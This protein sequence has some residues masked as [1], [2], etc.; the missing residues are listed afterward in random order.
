MLNN[1]N[2][3]PGWHPGSG[4]KNDCAT[5]CSP[6]SAAPATSAPVI[7]LS[8]ARRIGGPAWRRLR[9]LQTLKDLEAA[10]LATH[11]FRDPALIAPLPEDRRG[12]R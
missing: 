10:Y 8:F 4:V 1:E 5:K 7:P 6:A 12:T 2:A 11:Y 3:A 9:G